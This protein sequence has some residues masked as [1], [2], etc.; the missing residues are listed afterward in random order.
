MSTQ[1]T[2]ATTPQP[3]SSDLEFLHDQLVELDLLLFRF[4]VRTRQL[5]GGEPSQRGLYVSDEEFTQLLGRVPGRPLWEMG[6]AAPAPSEQIKHLSQLLDTHRTMVEGRLKA[7]LDNGQMPR[8]VALARQLDL[9]L[10]DHSVLLIATAA[11]L[12]LRYE[13]ICGWLHDDLTR[14]R[15]SVQLVLDLF[16][17]GL[18][19]RMEGLEQLQSGALRRH[20]IIDVQ[21][22]KSLP[23]LRHE[24]C[25]GTGVISWLAGRSVS[26]TS[27]ACIEQFEPDPQLVEK[28][29]L[30]EELRTRIEHIGQQQQ[31]GTYYLR[32]ISGTGRKSFARAVCGVRRES[33][34][35]VD[36]QQARRLPESEFESL[37][38]LLDRAHFLDG[39]AICWTDIDSLTGNELATRRAQIFAMYHRWRGLTFWTGRIAL[40][41]SEHDAKGLPIYEEVHLSAP[42][43]DLRARLWQRELG[44]QVADEAHHAVTNVF[45]FTPGKI[46]DASATAWLHARSRGAD[47]PNEQDVLAAA[48]RHATP[49]LG[50]LAQSVTTPHSWDELM[51][52]PTQRAQ[53]HEIVRRQ[54][55]KGTVLE[56]WGFGRKMS[57]SH[58]VSALFFG[59][60][61]TGKTMGAAIVA[62]EVSQDLYRI[63]LSQVVSKYIGETEK[64]LEKVFSEAEAADAALLFD[65]AD[66]L[67]GKRGEIQAADDRYANIEVG[68]LLQRI[69]AFPGLMILATNLRRNMDQ[70]FLRRLQVIVEF[71]LPDRVSRAKIWS[72]IWPSEAP[73]ESSIDPELLAERFELSGGHIRNIALAAAYAAAEEGCSIGMMHVLEAA[74]R[75]YRKL[76]KL[77]D[78]EKF[79]LPR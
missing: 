65:E 43:R 36:G 29:L 46:H 58:G 13:R 25:L 19:Q 52:P 20:R 66:A 72:T 78:A 63:D 74:R 26:T 67:F 15:P 28:L 32:G 57:G 75:E 30:D 79:E 53:L 1:S 56:K 45:R 54:R 50:Q 68:Y 41:E 4:A 69:E 18:G 37:L 8:L 47:A 49:R 24:V 2:D 22:K 16:A 35:I 64:H 9:S 23:F 60:P 55:Q 70:A 33:L 40:H 14:R 77:V 17:P 44:S 34:L 21:A 12:D 3:Y 59:P 62:R 31:G 27:F 51:L 39:S 48:R 76:N 6:D 38:A 11:E 73:I 10:F 61:G 5:T 71:P 7:T 42:E